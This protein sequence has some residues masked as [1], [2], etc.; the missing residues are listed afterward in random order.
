M[1]N[2][3]GFCWLCFCS[4]LSSS[5]NFWFSCSQFFWLWFATP[6]SMCASTP[7]RLVLSRRNLGM[8]SCGTGS[9]TWYRQ[10]LEVFCSRLFLDSCGLMAGQVSLRPKICWEV[11][12]LPVLTGVSTLLKELLSPGNFCVWRTVAQDQLRA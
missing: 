5:G 8:E 4:C 6:E 3:L 7:G 10:K 11:V 9:A 2:S 12:V 1:P